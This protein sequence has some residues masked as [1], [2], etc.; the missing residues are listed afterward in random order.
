MD[1]LW[2][3]FHVCDLMS[4]IT[5]E[6]VIV[7]YWQM[8]TVLLRKCKEFTHIHATSSE[9]TGVEVQPVIAE[10][11]ALTPLPPLSQGFGFGILALYLYLRG[12]TEN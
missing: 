10:A 12:G 5:E 8:R 11:Q 4:A 3:I 1:T 9:R 7:P 2:E 6:G